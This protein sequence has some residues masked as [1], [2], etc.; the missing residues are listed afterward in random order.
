P[1]R[2]REQLDSFF[3]FFPVPTLFLCLLSSLSLSPLTL[4]LISPSP[5]PTPS[6]SLS[7]HTHDLSHFLSSLGL[8]FFSLTHSL[9]SLTPPLCLSSLTVPLCLSSLSHT[10]TPPLSLL[11]HSLSLCHSSITLP[12]S[13][14]L[15]SLTLPLSLSLSVSLTP[16]SLSVP[17]LSHSPSLTLCLSSLTFSPSLS[18]LSHTLSLSV[19]PLS[20]PP[21]LTLPPSPSHTPSLPLSFCLSSLTLPLS[22]WSTPPSPSVRTHELRRHDGVSGRQRLR[23]RSASV[24]A[25]GG[26]GVVCACARGKSR[27]AAVGG[28]LGVSARG[29]AAGRPVARNESGAQIN[30]TTGNIDASRILNLYQFTQLYREITVQASGVLT[31]DSSMSDGTTAGV[32]SVSSS[33]ASLWLGKIKQMTDEEECCI[34]MDGR[35]D[36]IL[37]CAHSFCQKCIDKWSDRNRNCPICRL[38]V[39]EAGDSWVVSEA[40]TEED[41]ASYILNLADEAGQPHKP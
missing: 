40:P 35:A 17:P 38:Q 15:S 1:S 22:L 21:P 27:A 20:L 9:S 37:P 29:R 32:S 24:Q 6:L 31:Q 36:L 3:F 19:S 14:C 5:T 4:S 11:S 12:L 23:M 30:K 18:L 25:G 41:I 10:P 8:C 34:C 7:F 26:G 2:T 28:R 39:T 16:P 13:L 33:H